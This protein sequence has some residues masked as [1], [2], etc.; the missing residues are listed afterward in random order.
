APGGPPHTSAGG[1][2]SFSAPRD[3][4]PRDACLGADRMR[5][6]SLGGTRDR[7]ATAGEASAACPPDR[8]ASRHKNVPSRFVNRENSLNWPDRGA[9]RSFAARGSPGA[10]RRSG[11][12]RRNTPAPFRDPRR[13]GSRSERGLRRREAGDCD[14][15]RRAGDV[16][17]A[18]A[19]ADADRRGVAAVLAADADLEAAPR[20]AALLHGDLHQA[21][22]ADRIERLER[23]ARVDL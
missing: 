9:R 19:V 10:A 14:A 1:R 15:E 3:S 17:E 12:T 4:G 16:V 22:D 18:E 7:R 6:W 5:A 21:A 13:L 20:A 11:V 2:P 8:C 23:V